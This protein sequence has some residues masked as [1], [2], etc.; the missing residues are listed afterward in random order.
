[1]EKAAFM[2]RLQNATEE[3][4][5]N[6]RQ[7]VGEILAPIVE[8]D[9]EGFQNEIDLA[10]KVNSSFAKRHNIPR[11]IHVRFTRRYMRDKILRRAREQNLIYKGKEVQIAKETPWIMRKKRMEYE[12]LTATL[13]DNDISYRW[14]IPERLMFTFEDRHYKINSTM[15]AE[16]FIKKNEKKLWHKGRK[17]GR[18]REEARERALSSESSNSERESGEEEEEEEGREEMG[19]EEGESRKVGVETRRQKKHRGRSKK[20]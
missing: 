19:E 12:E 4:Q 20:D 18:Q 11:K 1:M 14:L 7:T 8:M 3:T 13:R 15:K 10:Y 17:K 16:E 9:V 5:E 2:L 6:V